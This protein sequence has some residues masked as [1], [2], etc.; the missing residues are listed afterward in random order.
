MCVFYFPFLICVV[1]NLRVNRTK[2]RRLSLPA[3]RHGPRLRSTPLVTF[4]TVSEASYNVSSAGWCRRMFTHHRSLRGGGGMSAIAV[5][6]NLIHAPQKTIIPLLIFPPPKD[7]HLLYRKLSG[8]VD[9]AVHFW[10]RSASLDS[11]DKQ[12]GV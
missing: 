4:R 2:F 9:I 5:K 3:R 12:D 7:R 10:A 11:G 6:M 8:Y 1:V